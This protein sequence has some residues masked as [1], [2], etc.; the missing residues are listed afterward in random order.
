MQALIAAEGPYDE[1]CN[2]LI[3][4]RIALWDVLAASVRPGSMD[5]DIRTETAS[6]NDFAAFFAAHPNLELICFNGQKAAQLYKRL[7]G[8]GVMDSYFDFEILPSTSPAYAAMRYEQK[9]AHWS[10][11]LASVLKL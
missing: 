11:V 9:L 8:P 6:G 1:R 3:V 2:S 4:N 5:A 7:I 10:A